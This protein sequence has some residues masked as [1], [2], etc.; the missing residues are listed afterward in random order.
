VYIVGPRG[1]AATRANP[2]T[3]DSVVRAIGVSPDSAR[4]LHDPPPLSATLPDTYFDYQVEQLAKELPNNAQPRYPDPLRADGVEG[5]VTAQFIIDSTGR[6]LVGSFKALKSANTLFTLAVFSVLPDLRFTPAQVKGHPVSELVQ[7]QYV[8]G[9]F[10]R[11]VTIGDPEASVTISVRRDS[12]WLTLRTPKGTFGVHTDSSTMAAWA[13]SAAHVH[14]PVPHGEKK[15]DYSD[16]KLT[17]PEPSLNAMVTMQFVRMADSSSPYLIVGSNGSWA[18]SIELPFESVQRV[19]SAMHRSTSTMSV[20]RENIPVFDRSKP[21]F[22]FQVEQQARPKP[23]NSPGY[24]EA[25]RSR[26]VEGETLF[27]FVVDTTGMVDLSSVRVLKSSHPLFALAVYQKLPRM[28]FDPAVLSGRR[29]KEIVQQPY[30]F[31]LSRR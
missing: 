7:V 3:V 22:N 27:Q 23:G 31:N 9:W 20:W 21:Y 28:R 15:F 2:A 18:G 10:D 17:Y 8:F 6:P 16:S 11:P 13:D 19:F 24:P 12:A 1:T 25:L 14:G 26:N 5:K 29:V 30:N 4:V